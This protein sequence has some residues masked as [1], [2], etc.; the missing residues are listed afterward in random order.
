MIMFAPPKGCERVGESTHERREQRR[1][2]GIC[3]D[4]QKQR[5][6][7]PDELQV[8][9]ELDNIVRSHSCFRKQAM[10]QHLVMGGN[11]HI[12]HRAGSLSDDEDKEEHTA[13]VPATA[14]RAPATEPADPFPKVPFQPAPQEPAT[15]EQV[16]KTSTM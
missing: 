9:G 15:A 1:L 10:R 13:Q 16:E 12:P 8:V 6:I 2:G 3:V 11:A 4:W 5:A 7:L 14:Y